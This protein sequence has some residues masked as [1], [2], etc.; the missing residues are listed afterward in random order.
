MNFVT[1]RLVRKEIL[2]NMLK[3]LMKVLNI[4]VIVVITQTNQVVI[5]VITKEPFIKG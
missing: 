3:Q 4:S 2:V 5:S 1:I